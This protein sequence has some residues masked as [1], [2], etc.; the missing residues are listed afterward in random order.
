MFD[1][2]FLTFEQQVNKNKRH[3]LDLRAYKGGAP[4]APEQKKETYSAWGNTATQDGFT[5]SKYNADQ[6]SYLQGAMPELQNKLFDYQGADTQA[7]AMADATK[8]NGMKSFKRDADTLFGGYVADSARRFGSLNN[9][10]YDSDM[11]R[12]GQAT[13]DGLQELQNNYDANYQ[14]NLSNIQNYNLQNLNT[15]QNGIGNLYN[16]ANGQSQQALTSSNATNNFNQQ[17]YSTA[18]QGYLADQQR[19]SSQWSALGGA[20]GGIGTGV[21]GYFYNKGNTPPTTKL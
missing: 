13:N 17:N 21:G 12:F 4:K 1:E 8:A 19:K 15:A 5:P 3:K 18:M 6:M 10:S 9:S 14:N 11:K 7:R 2:L 20:I 16:L